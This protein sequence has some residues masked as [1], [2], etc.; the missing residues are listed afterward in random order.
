MTAP[1]MDDGM[2]E[3]EPT[4]ERSAPRAIVYLHGF[5]SSPASFK[6]R[7][8]EAELHRLGHDGIF[9]APELPASPLL[10]VR[11]A[12][13]L[14]IIALDGATPA[15]HLVIVGS[16][17]GG[18]YATV[19]AERLGCRAVLINPAVN[20]Q[21]D[22]SP[23]VGTH[24]YFHDATRSFEFLPSYVDELRALEPAAITRPERYFLIAATG[25]EV[26]DWRESAARYAGARQT[27]VQGSDHGLSDFAEHLPAILDFCGIDGARPA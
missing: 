2:F 4:G 14:S 7:E 13:A 17:L 6:S 20:A 27:I 22:L 5:R 23:L 1:H 19:V 18:L 21:R 25:D 11:L 3:P 15:E 26:L 16:S 12:L 8:L 9:H 10:A 24:T